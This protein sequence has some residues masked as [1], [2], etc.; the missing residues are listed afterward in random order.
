MGTAP[1]ARP[2]RRNLHRLTRAQALKRAWF[3]AA[4]SVVLLGLILAPGAGAAGG[5]T[6][7]VFT[8]AYTSF[9]D[10]MDPQ[11]SYTAEGWTAMYDTY[12]PLLTYRHAEGK[13][14]SEVIPGLAKA[15]PRITGG[16]KTYTLFLRRGLKYSDGAPVRASDFKFTVERLFRVN[17]GGSPFYTDIVGARSFAR[18]Q[19]AH[20]SGI[21][22]DD[23]RGKIVIHLVKPSGTFS[24]LL[25]LLFV[26]PLP[27]DTP[28]RDQTFHPPPATGPYVITSSRPG[29]GW[30]YARNPAWRKNGA[31]MPEI[32]GGHV[33]R[34]EIAVVRD[35]QQQV[36]E[37]QS[38]RL[39]WLFDPPPAD[40]HLELEGGRGGT[41]QRVEPTLST[42][43]F[44][45][46][47]K[48]PPFDDLK[49]R[50]AVEY[51]VDPSKL[52][53][54]YSGQVAPTDQILPPGMPGYEPF[55]LYPTNMQMARQLIR[56][57]D[58]EDRSIT[59]WTD[60]ESPNDD[61]GVYY[62][63]VLQ[64]LG[65][66]ATLKVVNPDN[67]FTLIGDPGTPNLDTGFADWFED[68]A[69]PDDF[70]QPLLASKPTRFN[71]SNFPQLVAPSLNQ[72]VAA[73][74][75][76]SPPIDE[77]AYAALDRSYMALAPIVPYGTRTLT[78]SF[79]R[80]VDLSGFV[81][82]PTFEADLTSFKLR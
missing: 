33:G 35:Q 63:G 67:Y 32:P 82:N 57:A 42:Y 78:A 4:L 46:N 68:Y 74:A 79:S 10:Y 2:G 48:Q 47:T 49:V 62:R 3:A 69:H 30:D 24:S 73:L 54:I 16:G 52:A 17:S 36:D 37:L 8:G 81:W 11:L 12:I 29:L 66:H 58:P 20:I 61:A 23:R 39:D 65:F 71:N 21:T 50:Q 6:Q 80:D 38:G 27:A 60:S 1:S 70:F 53:L 31:R 77:P 9:P 41:Q 45:L 18:E 76:R 25:A 26:A 64:E 75:R 5:T 55:D 59:V 51:A 40:R 7:P 56:E 34:I 22:T 19:R 43:Y 15:L 14:G 13:A 44:W 28:L 72:E